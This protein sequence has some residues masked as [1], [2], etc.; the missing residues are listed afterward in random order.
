MLLSGGV[1]SSTALVR[2]LRTN[3]HLKNAVEAIYL[4]IWLEDEFDSLFDC[5]WQ[6]DL[7]FVRKTCAR[8]GVP[9]REVNLQREYHQHVIAHTLDELRKGA[10]PSPDLRCNSEIK[11]GLIMDHFVESDKVLTGHYA[12]IRTHATTQSECILNTRDRATQSQVGLYCSVDSTK[13]QTYFLSRLTARQLERIEFPLADMTKT[14][15]RAFAAMHDLPSA[16]R[17]D[18]QGICFLGNVPYRQF[19][20][21][22]LGK[23]RGKIVSVNDGAVLGYHDGYWFYT[24]GQRTGLGLGGGPWY[25]SEKNVEENTI[26]VVHQNSLEQARKH[27]V[28]LDDYNWC[29]ADFD[30]H[31]GAVSDNVT[32]FAK[33]NDKT[34][35]KT[36]NKTDAMTNT[37]DKKSTNASISTMLQNQDDL[38]VKLRHGPTR[39][40]ARFISPHSVELAQGDVGIATGQYCVIYQKDHVLGSAR[41]IGAKNQEQ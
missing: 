29:S 27:V 10:T 15:V 5:P 32:A 21:Y 4:K 12:A 17:K 34:N 7:S 1:D 41:I 25:V 2:F 23:K 33:T 3:P 18:S 13:D 31:H 37:K 38:E 20:A 40:R 36:N 35:N 24:I 16:K 28:V 9:L 30:T 8:F 14:Q 11:F 19:I 22:H 6:E 39:I 26:Y